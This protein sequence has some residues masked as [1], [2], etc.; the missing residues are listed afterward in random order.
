MAAL[1]YSGWCSHLK[2]AVIFLK[3]AF[4]TTNIKIGCGSSCIV[5]KDSAQKTKSRLHIRTM[6]NDNI[7]SIVLSLYPCHKHG[8]FY[9]GMAKI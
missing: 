1:L 7:F 2:I 5:C 3:I 6:V 9:T 4:G 8:P